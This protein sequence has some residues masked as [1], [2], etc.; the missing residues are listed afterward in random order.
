[1]SEPTLKDTI[2]TFATDFKAHQ[3]AV[4][5]KFE[6]IDSKGQES[7]ESQSKIAEISESLAKQSEQIEEIKKAAGRQ[8]KIQLD[9]KQTP[10][11]LRDYKNALN[12]KLRGNHGADDQLKAAEDAF[13]TEMKADAG[14]ANEY[15]TLYVGSDPDGGFGVGQE[16]GGML[17]S[18]ITEFSNMR[19]VA[20]VRNGMK[21]EL[22]FTVNKKGGS[23]V[24]KA[25]ELQAY[26]KGTTPNLGTQII[27]AHIHYALPTI[28]EQMLE[29]SDFDVLGWLGTEVG[30]SFASYDDNQFFNGDGAGEAKGI[31]TRTT[32][33]TDALATYGK[34]RQYNSG[35]ATSF[36]AENLIE[37]SGGLKRPYYSGRVNWFVERQT[38]FTQLATLKNG[39]DDFRL[40]LPDFTNEVTFKMLGY[41][42]MFAPDMPVGSVG[43]NKA[44]AFGNFG[45]AYT[46]YDRTGVTVKR[47]EEVESPE[48]W[49]RYRRR[50]GG[51][52]T[53]FEAYKLMQ[54]SV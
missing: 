9:G 35:G 33:A 29:D 54:M 30:E 10:K 40:V 15:K 8:P 53:N 3:D 39:D 48:V 25:S 49:F 26:V 23:N 50:N 7:A 41:D 28:S 47:F 46:I 14:F 31:L 22:K 1:M 27:P 34:V 13:K 12:A 11:V 6:E 38:F 51:D 18:S 43:G 5:Q 45:R 24:V 32:A 19:Q 21:P 20:T 52:V 17:E 2:E 42:V 4:K 37:M 36:V 16:D 44:L